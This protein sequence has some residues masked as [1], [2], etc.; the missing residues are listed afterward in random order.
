MS[1]F[2]GPRPARL[3]AATTAGNASLSAVRRV[4]RRRRPSLDS[5]RHAREDAAVAAV[6]AGSRPILGDG[7]DPCVDRRED[8]LVVL[9]ARWSVGRVARRAAP[10]P[11]RP[12]ARTSA[13]SCDDR[14]SGRGSRRRRRAAT[15]PDMPRAP[16]PA[17]ATTRPSRASRR[18][19]VD[20]RLEPERRRFGV[21][22]PPS[23][24]SPSQVMVV[25][26][27]DDHHLAR[28]AQ[29]RTDLPQHGPRG[30]ER[31]AH[32]ALAQ[33]E[34]VAEQHQPVASRKRLRQQRGAR[35]RARAARRRRHATPGAGRRRPAC[36]ACA[37]SA[38]GGPA[39]AS[40]WRI[41]LGSM[42]RTSS[43]TTSSSSTSVGAP[44]VE[45]SHEP[46]HE[47]LGRAGAGRDP[48]DPLALQPLL[49]D[50]GLVV[51]QVRV[52]AVLAR[53][54]DQAVGVRRVARADHEHEVALA[55]Q[56]LDGRLAVGGGVT[57]VVGA[58]SDDRREALAQA[59]DDRARLV[60][61]QRR[62]RDVGD[63]ARGPRPRARR[64][65]ASFSI[66]TMLAG[67]S[68]IVPSTSSWPA[69]PTSTIV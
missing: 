5:V 2:S 27:G 62:L 41:V 9:G 14:R 24:H 18:L 13:R 19:P 54:L 8:R 3:S 53:D 67:A 42:K 45:E 50:L 40:A 31:L 56:L 17:R 55:R 49:A 34:H 57:D 7:V 35:L 20:R 60:N 33:L 30:A 39:A 48:H 37:V 52:G 68:P 43:W 38:L 16:A 51:D 63:L 64:R 47:L 69:W 59:V 15:R 4:L 36:A 6:P 61:R 23:S 12:G 29:R 25:I 58:R 66:S 32:R 21:A 44:V 65:P 46:L 10:S 1:A 26:A 28:R 11:P 22:R